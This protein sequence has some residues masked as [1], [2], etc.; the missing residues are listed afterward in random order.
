MICVTQTILCYQTWCVCIDTSESLRA[1]LNIPDD[2]IVFGSM[3]G[4][5]EYSLEYVKQ[6]VIDIS[7]NPEFNNIYFVYLNIDPFG[8]SNE[9]IKFLPGT[10]DMKYKRMF[11]NTCDAM[12]YARKGGET[13]GLA[14]GEFS[15]CDKP[16]IARPGEHSKAHEVILGNDMIHHTNYNECYEIITNWNKYKKDVS[17]N[18]YKFYSPAHAMSTFNTYLR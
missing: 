9:R 17:N 18:G 15:I 12:L 16:V 8:P 14:C 7:N 10:S 5:D 3:S 13:F 11:I 6:A 1:E 4:A 2:A